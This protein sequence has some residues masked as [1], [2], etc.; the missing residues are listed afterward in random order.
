MNAAETAARLR[1]AAA[2]I[3]EVA[4]AAAEATDRDGLSL[5]TV[6]DAPRAVLDHLAL[7]QPAAARAA[8]AW[9][10]SEADHVT[11][12]A[13]QAA[14][15]NVLIATSDDTGDSREWR[16]RVAYSTTDK[17]LALADVILGERP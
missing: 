13:V 12:L 11:V 3:R 16:V 5:S 10:D 17:A 14:A 15:V 4:A 9:L 2:R 8:A 6:T 7:W 1:A